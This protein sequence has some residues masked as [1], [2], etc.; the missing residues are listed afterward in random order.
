MTHS[1]KLVLRPALKKSTCEKLIE[2][3]GIGMLSKIVHDWSDADWIQICGRISVNI[4]VQDVARLFWALG[5]PEA[6]RLK[7]ILRECI[8]MFEVQ[9][10]GTDKVRNDWSYSF[11]VWSLENH[12]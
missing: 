11:T 8:P 12:S 1:L 2:T 5:K 9:F 4:P 7:A 3:D 10:V 6:K